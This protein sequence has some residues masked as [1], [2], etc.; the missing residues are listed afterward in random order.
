MVKFCVQVALH[1]IKNGRRFIIE[2]PE[3]SALWHT[4]VMRMLLKQDGVT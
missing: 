1:Q 4:M 3:T 2:N